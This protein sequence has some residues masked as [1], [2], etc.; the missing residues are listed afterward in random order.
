VSDG[1]PVVLQGEVMLL[2]WSETA[3]GG[4]KIVL[5]LEGPEALT[6]FRSLTLAKRGI[7]GQRL[8]CMMLL[9]PDDD[10]EMSQPGQIGPPTS[11]RPAAATHEPDSTLAA[12]EAA[13]TLRVRCRDASFHAWLVREHGINPP[14]RAWGVGQRQRWAERA[15]CEILELPELDDIDPDCLPRVQAFI[16]SLPP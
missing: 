13:E 11:D 5:Q 16:E 9:L 2:D 4:A 10:S 15:V 6:P 12:S 14:R 3:K 7:A 8:A 1:L